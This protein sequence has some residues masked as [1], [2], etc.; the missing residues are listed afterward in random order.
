MYGEAI[1]ELQ[2]AIR[3]FPSALEARELLREVNRQ[4]MI[5]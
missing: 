1:R 4:R 5:R 2:I 3:V